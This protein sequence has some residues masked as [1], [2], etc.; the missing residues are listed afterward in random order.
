M[1]HSRWC[2]NTGINTGLC[3]CFCFL[4]QQGQAPQS[5]WDGAKVILDGDITALMF[6]HSSLHLVSTSQHRIPSLSSSSCR[7]IRPARCISSLHPSAQR[8]RIINIYCTSPRPCR[9]KPASPNLV[10]Y[11]AEVSAYP[12]LPPHPPRSL[13][14]SCISW[15]IQFC[16][17][18]LHHT[19]VCNISSSNRS[20]LP[21]FFCLLSVGDLKLEG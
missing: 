8:V 14:F 21:C 16:A 10:S 17:S 20:L 15:E 13:F 2:P 18:A 12:S 5:A 9:H 3:F 6:P 19:S 1:F 11:V 4:N 7:D